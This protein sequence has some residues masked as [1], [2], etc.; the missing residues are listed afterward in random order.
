MIGAIA[1]KKHGLKC[2]D[3]RRRINGS[4]TGRATRGTDDVVGVS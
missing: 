2:V 1:S 4:V 3:H